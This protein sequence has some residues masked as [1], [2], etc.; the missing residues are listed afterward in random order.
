MKKQ[1]IIEVI[2]FLFIV[3]FLYAAGTKL[4]EYKMFVAQIGIS[5]LLTNYATTIAWMIPTIEIV[6]SLMLIIPRFRTAGL[7]AA[8]GL[9]VIFTFYIIA[10]FSIS[11]KLPCACGGVFGILGWSWHLVFNI[12]FVLLGL[13][14]IILNNKQEPQKNKLATA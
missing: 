1:I 4:V 5:P 3:L 8:F 6:I 7:Y 11:T 12:G 2:V 10:I 13:V 14:A 9:M